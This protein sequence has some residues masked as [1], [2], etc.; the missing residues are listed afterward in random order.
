MV[1]NKDQNAQFSRPSAFLMFFLAFVGLA[2][3]ATTPTITGISAATADGSYNAGEVINISATFSEAVMINA[4]TPVLHLETGDTDRDATYAYGATTT[5]L[6]FLYTVQAGDTASDLDYKAIDSLAGDIRGMTIDHIVANNTLAAPGTTGSLGANKAIV[7]D[8]TVPTLV[9]T[10]ND[11]ALKAGDTATITFDF[12]QA[13]TDF[14]E[15]DVSAP[16]GALSGFAV[17]GSNSSKYTATFTPTTN[18]IAATNVITVGTSW[19]DAAG[20]APSGSTTSSN[21]AVDTQRPSVVITLSDS[22]LKVGDTATVT[23]DFSKE[24]TNFT[25]NDVTAPNG[26]LSAFAVDGSNS[27]KYTA[28]FTPTT[29]TSDA[30]NVI[31]VGTV[32]TDASGNAPSGDAT[33]ANYAVETTTP[34]VALRYS[35]NPVKAGALVIIATY[36]EAVATPTIAINQPGTTDVAATPMTDTG[37]HSYFSYEYTVVANDGDTYVDGTATVTLST[38]ADAAGNNAAAAINT[39]FVIDTTAPTIAI[40]D[41]VT[42][43]AN[44]ESVILYTFTFNENVTGFA[45]N[46]AVVAHGTKAEAFS[47]GTSGDAIYTL[48]VTPDASSTTAITVDVAGDVATDAAG[49]GNTAATQSTQ[50][51]D[52][53][54]PT[55]TITDDEAGTANIAGEAITYTFTFSK[56]VMNFLTADINVTNGT[57]GTFNVVSGTEY[58]LVVT[59][60]SDYEGNILVNVAAGVAQ[61]ING[62]NNTA[63]TQSTQAVDTLRPNITG[64]ALGADGYIN[65]ADTASGVNIVV[66]TTDIEDGRTVSCSITDVGSV[67]TVGPVTGSASS[68]TVTIASTALTALSDGVITATCSVSDTAGN[69]A[70]AG[71]DTATKD[72]VAPSG[73]T[74]SIDPGYVNN[75]NKSAFA[76]TFAGATAGTTYVYVITT[77]GGA[78]IATG[79]GTIATATDNI[80]GINVTSVQDGTLTLSTYLIDPAGNNGANTTDTVT[81]DVVAPADGSVTYTSG[82]YTTA[83]VAVTYA[84]GT[85]S[86]SGLNTATAII[87]RKE[88]TLTNGVCD[89]YGAFSTIATEF[90]GSYTDTGVVTNKCY[91]YQ[92]QIT[93][94]AGNTVNYTSENVAKVDTTAPTVVALSSD[95]R[96]YNESTTYPLTIMANFTESLGVEPTITVVTSSQTVTPTVANCGDSNASTWCFNYTAPTGIQLLDTMTVHISA[97]QDLAT[98]TMVADNTHTFAIDTVH[99]NKYKVATLSV[100]WNGFNLPKRVLQNL[101]PA[102]TN[103]YTVQN[104]LDTKGGLTGSYDY[105]QYC[106]ST[107]S[108]SGNCWLSYDPASEVNSMTEF[109]DAGD[110]KYWIHVTSGNIFLLAYKSLA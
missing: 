72:V 54:L 19:T 11:Y 55:V 15:A 34:A 36:S 61:D 76:F 96:T 92:Y 80:L 9:I 102:N 13:P 25:V 79:N 91:M 49:N 20:N 40:T 2:A 103:N 71:T 84:N 33:S 48:I 85:D 26:E 10:L 44:S 77:S 101:S 74:V 57:V 99:T 8:T 59:P 7:I 108:G 75:A 58:T 95:S 66:N 82:Y 46:E 31:T 73:Y 90:D 29:N 16:N 32:W 50:A 70:T 47:S 28:T 22:A 27:S 37:N 97:A 64:V 52:T 63:A 65:A 23:F 105:V 67:H 94:N 109:N 88:A 24:P 86:G 14:A 53:V 69:A 51:V 106:N 87:Q 21:Y 110:P 60:L 4:G 81:K 1:S 78:G 41:N 3:A 93:D 104:V 56:A 42:G 98:N 12:S 45:V 17:D 6:Y 83:S 39:T 68:N 18:T 89:T 107:Y 35:S 43:T 62:N 100:G 5:T 38:V 30:T